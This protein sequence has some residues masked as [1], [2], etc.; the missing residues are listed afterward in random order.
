MNSFVSAKK[1]CCC[2]FFGESL[3]FSVYKTI[4]SA[5]RDYLNSSFPF[6]MSFISFSCLIALARTSCT[7]LNSND[8]SEYLCPL[9]LDLEGKGFPLSIMLT[10][11]LWLLLSWGS[12]LPFLVWEHFCHEI[13]LNFF[14]YFASIDMLICVLSFVLLIRYTTLI[15]FSCFEPSFHSV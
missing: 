3:G 9:V 6:Y 8:K 1:G 14:K 11:Y 7:M 12:L 15:D 13:V 4:S 5:N 2:F 10:F